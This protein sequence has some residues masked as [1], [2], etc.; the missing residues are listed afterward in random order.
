MSVNNILFYDPEEVFAINE[1]MLLEV[2]T[3]VEGSTVLYIDNFYKNPELVE[4][5]ILRTPFSNN[6]SMFTSAYNGYRIYM[7]AVIQNKEFF[8]KITNIINNAFDLTSILK[9]NELLLTPK[10]SL[11]A[12]LYT[13]DINKTN[14]NRNNMP[15]S[16]PAIISAL[17]Y[18][19]NDPTM[20]TALY[21]H[22]ES[23]TMYVPDNSEQFKLVSSILDEELVKVTNDTIAYK[24]HSETFTVDDIDDMSVSKS[25]NFEVTHIVTPKYN[26]LVAFVSCALHAPIV[27]YVKLSKNNT[28]RLNQVLFLHNSETLKR[29]GR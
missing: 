15:H 22:K 20:G 5:L 4:N 25:N 29:G 3:T 14:L 6:T 19:D 23:G 18:F 24:N 10:R 8:V 28:H 21:K 13:G 2:V 27:D 26:R 17:V 16:D 12:N 1:D 11:V 7:E 9:P